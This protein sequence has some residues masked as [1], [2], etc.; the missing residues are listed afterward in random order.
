VIWDA[1][2]G[3]IIRRLGTPSSQVGDVRGDLIA[4]GDDVGP[5]H[6]TD[7][8]TGV[9][10]ELSPSAGVRSFD[11]TTTRFAPDGHEIAVVESQSG[12]VVLGRSSLAAV[13][14]VA[15]GRVRVATA[16]VLQRPLTLLW[17]SDGRRLYASAYS[18]DA[19]T[20][21]LAELVPSDGAAR[22][23]RVSFGGIVGRGMALPRATA[24]PLL[25][26]PFGDAARCPP[27]TA[28]PNVAARPCAF[29]P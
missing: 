11:V 16:P 22:I 26:A 8:S 4:W 13:L 27:T 3:R 10:R 23:T 9:D 24:R 7:L 17:S 1:A 29:S 18:R 28:F 25:E 14:D 12:A 15:T 21:V 6:V 20:T 2:S 19:P 5:L